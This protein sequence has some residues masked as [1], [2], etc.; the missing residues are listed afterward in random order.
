MNPGAAAC[1]VRRATSAD[2]DGILRC[3]HGDFEP[4]RGLYTPEASTDTVLTPVTIHLRLLTMAIFVAATPEDEIVGTICSS[5]CSCQPS[6]GSNPAS[7]RPQR[8]APGA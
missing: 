3:L 5:M 2:S 1:T 7:R 8:A 6:R 4:Y